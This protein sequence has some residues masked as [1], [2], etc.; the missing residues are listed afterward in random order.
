MIN[1]STKTHVAGIWKNRLNKNVD[2]QYIPNA[3][4]QLVLS[5]SA[6]NLKYKPYQIHVILV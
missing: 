6:T 2:T 3:T 4:V 5:V 1:F